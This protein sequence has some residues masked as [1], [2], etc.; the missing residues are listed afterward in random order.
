M[1]VLEALAVASEEFK[2]PPIDL[3]HVRRKISRHIRC[4]CVCT[5]NSSR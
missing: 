2:P 4:G 3:I 5:S 1:E